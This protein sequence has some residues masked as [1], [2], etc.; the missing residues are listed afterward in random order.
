[1]RLRLSFFA[2]TLVAC[3]AAQPEG[4]AA[5]AET[6][7]AAPTSEVEPP[8]APVVVTSSTASAV[9]SGEPQERPDANP[10]PANAEDPQPTSATPGAFDPNAC[11]RYFAKARRCTANALGAMDATQRAEV[12]QTLEQS[13]EQSRVAFGQL[14]ASVSSKIC[15]DAIVAFDQMPNC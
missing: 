12:M 15:A 2:T 11:A 13:L 4:P 7:S 6:T 8:V 5:T 1:M 10:W 9:A 3:A 14:E